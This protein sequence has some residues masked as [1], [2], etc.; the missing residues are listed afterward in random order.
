MR[1]A[2]H[3]VLSPGWPAAISCCLAFACVSRASEDEP[4]DVAEPGRNPAAIVADAF[5]GA[6]VRRSVRYLGADQRE[7]AQR[8]S[9]EKNIRNV[10]YAYDVFHDGQHIATAYFDKHRVRTLPETLMVAVTPSNTV[11]RVQVI[12]FTEPERYMPPPRWYTTFKNGTLAPQRKLSPAIDG[13][14]GATLTHRATTRAVKR[15]LAAHQAL[16]MDDK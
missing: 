5:G 16:G 10:V 13:V 1:K 7:T 3:S 6:E 14:T 2:C 4:G 9:G 8:L 12:S 15:T 11:E